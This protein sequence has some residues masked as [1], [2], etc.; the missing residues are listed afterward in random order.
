[1]NARLLQHSG[2]QPLV[3]TFKVFCEG[4]YEGFSEQLAASAHAT[5]Q[6]KSALRLQLF[7]YF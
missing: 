7:G 3:E 2:E 6:V 5:L 4:F 1:M